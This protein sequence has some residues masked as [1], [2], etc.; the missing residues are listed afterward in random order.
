MSLLIV[1]GKFAATLMKNFSKALQQSDRPIATSEEACISVS[2]FLCC[3]RAQCPYCVACFCIDLMCSYLCRC[4][5]FVQKKKH[6]YAK[7]FL[8]LGMGVP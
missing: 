6:F 2:L 5:V 7:R 4:Y 3:L 1:L 8:Q